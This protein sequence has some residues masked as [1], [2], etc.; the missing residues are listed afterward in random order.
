MKIYVIG[1]V[2]KN[3]NEIKRVAEKFE[4]MGNEVRYVKKEFGV[5]LETLIHNCYLHIDSW[6]DIIVAV[7]KSIVK[8]YVD[9]GMDTMYEVEHAKSFSKPVLIYGS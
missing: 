7:P 9:I 1:S 8:G 3:E 4:A 2:N 6:A 5:P